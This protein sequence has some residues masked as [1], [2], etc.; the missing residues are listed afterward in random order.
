M[1][2]GAKGMTQEWDRMLREV[3]D[4]DGGL[5]KGPGKGGKTAAQ[6]GFVTC[7]WPHSKRMAGPELEPIYLTM[8]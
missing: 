8:T 4:L 1:H 3:K 2:A 6:R 7:P 5:G